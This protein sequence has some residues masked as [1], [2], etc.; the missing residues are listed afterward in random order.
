MFLR[1]DG[2]F[3]KP[4]VSRADAEHILAQH[5]E[6]P[7]VRQF[8]L[9]SLKKTEQT[10]EWCFDVPGLKSNY[11]AIMDW[12]VQGSFLGKTLFLKGEHSDYL[13]PSHQSEI[14]ALFPNS[15]AHLVANT[16][17]WLHAENQKL[18]HV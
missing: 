1:S 18:S 15:K 4:I 13:M 11:P 6:I 7:S 16:G 14:I 10:F 8:L 3:K 2:K 9:K 17:H 12:T 5:I